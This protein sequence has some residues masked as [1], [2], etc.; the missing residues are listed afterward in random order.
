M[1]NVCIR[2]WMWRNWRSADLGICIWP[3]EAELTV[4][5]KLSRSSVT[6]H[7]ARQLAPKM[8]I[9]FTW[10]DKPCLLTQKAKKSCPALELNYEEKEWLTMSRSRYVARYESLLNTLKVA[11]SK[12]RQ[13]SPNSTVTRG[14]FLLSILLTISQALYDNWQLWF[15]VSHFSY[16]TTTFRDGEQKIKNRR[17]PVRTLPLRLDSSF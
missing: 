10:D 12:W 14:H 9:Y 15:N 17:L 5:V 16:Q 8:L 7:Y 13:F 1:E 4:E 2:P 6:C 11:I 3:D